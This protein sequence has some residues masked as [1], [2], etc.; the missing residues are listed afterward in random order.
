MKGRDNKICVRSVIM[1]YGAESLAVPQQVGNH[2]NK[3]PSNDV[4]KTQK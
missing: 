1:C 2:Q 4:L 3:S